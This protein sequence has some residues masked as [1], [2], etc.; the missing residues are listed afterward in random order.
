MPLVNS[1]TIKGKCP[2]CGESNAKCGGPS[3]NHPVD[4]AIDLGKGKEMAELQRVE[5]TTPSGYK[6]VIKATPE[7][8]KRLRDEEASRTA[9][10]S[11]AESEAKQATAKNK[12]VEVGNTK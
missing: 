5:Y 12:M 3:T 10:E 9:R 8:A 6:T 11:A 1:Q 4:V 2:I 7:L